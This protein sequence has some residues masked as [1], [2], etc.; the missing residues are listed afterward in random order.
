[1][2]KRKEYIMAYRYKKNRKTRRAN[3][4]RYKI[5]T[6]VIDGL[7]N[8]DYVVHSY[9]KTLKSARAEARKTEKDERRLYDNPFLL[10]IDTAISSIKK[11]YRKKKR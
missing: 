9:A 3:Q 6:Y 10:H 1:M 7:Y 4:N 5:D 11:R 2:S 8:N